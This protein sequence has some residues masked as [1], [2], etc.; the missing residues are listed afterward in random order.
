MTENQT[1]LAE[2]LTNAIVNFAKS[3]D[4]MRTALKNCRDYGMTDVEIRDTILLNIPE[5]DHPAFL[6]QWPMLSMM[7]ATL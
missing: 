4:D 1:D 6:S 3:I 7:F 2:A 5:E